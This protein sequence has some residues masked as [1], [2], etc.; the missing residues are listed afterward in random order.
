MNDIVKPWSTTIVQ[1]SPDD[2]EFELALRLDGFGLPNLPGL[3]TTPTWESTGFW[4]FDQIVKS[5]A[6]VTWAGS[7]FAP[8][9]IWLPSFTEAVLDM[10]PGIVDGQ[11]IDWLA[12][13]HVTIYAV[14]WE[15][16]GWN[17][18]KLQ[19]DPFFLKATYFQP[20]VGEQSQASFLVAR[21]FQVS[22]RVRC[23]ESFDQTSSTEPLG[24]LQRVFQLIDRDHGLP[25]N[26]C[27]SLH[28]F[29]IPDPCR[30]SL[31]GVTISPTLTWPHFEKGTEQ[32]PLSPFGGTAAQQG[33][34]A[35]FI[36]DF[37]RALV[38]SQPLT[39]D[40]TQINVIVPQSDPAACGFLTR[41]FVPDSQPLFLFFLC[42]R[43][44]T[45]LHCTMCE[46]ELHIVQFDGLGL[47][48]L[49]KL[50]PVADLLKQHWQARGVV[51]SNKFVA[52]Q[53]RPDSC[54][55]LALAHFAYVLD[56]ISLEQLDHFEKLHD[57]L[58]KSSNCRLYAGPT[59]LGKDA[60][61]VTQSLETILSEKGVPPGELRGRIQSAIKTFGVAAIAKALDNKT[62]WPALKTL[63][64]SR[65]KP[66]LWVS[67]QELQAHI[68]ARSKKEYGVDIRKPRKNKEVKPTETSILDSAALTL[69][70]GLFVTNSGAPLQQLALSQVQKDACGIAFASAAEA[71]PFL[72]NGKLISPE[73]LNLLVIGSLAGYQTALPQHS[74]RVPAIYKGTNEPILVDVTSVQLGD[75]AVYRKTGTDAPEVAVHPNVVV[76]AHI[77][78]D[79]W[80]EH[81]EWS[82]LTAHP[83]RKLVDT[84]PI[85]QLCRAEECDHQCPRYHPSI[86]ETGIE[87]GLLDVWGLRWT[88]YDGGKSTPADSEVLSVYLR[89]PESSFNSLH[90]AS[91]NC[92]VFYEPR[93][94]DNPGPDSRYSVVWHPKM[95][96]GEA[97]HLVKTDDV[98]IA[99]CR[100][101]HKIGLRCWAKN[102]E[103]LHQQVCPD[104]PF[105]NC[106]VKSVFRI[107]PLPAGT[108]R[109]SLVDILKAF[110]WVAKPLAPC[111]GS[112]GRA[113]QIGSE[114]PPPSAFFETKSGWVSITKVRDQ[115]T[116]AKTTDLIATART[117][118]HIQGQTPAAASSSSTS[119]PWN[120]GH[121]PWGG[122]AGVGKV[123]TAPPSQHV[124]SKFDDVEQRL[125]SQVTESIAKGLEQLQAEPATR[126]QQV[127][128]QL[129]V[130]AQ[131]QQFLDNRLTADSAKITEIQTDCSHLAAAVNTC[132]T[133]IADQGTALQA[134][135]TEVS[136]QGHSLKQVSSEVASVSQHLTSQLDSYFSRQTEQIEAMLAKRQRSN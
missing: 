4:I 126:I 118:Q 37:A 68:Q 82:E 120:V 102:Y 93:G 112:Q 103:A 36:L 50:R 89:I 46:E 88:K 19:L 100:L 47:T 33:L 136:T 83:I 66:F 69:P 51:L 65:P 63:G 18:V 131:Q 1:L 101:G 67:H 57:G 55:T 17:L 24:S 5:Q 45:F 14:V 20:F 84:F 90:H 114:T 39:I 27:E 91:G 104:K 30:R 15:T 135:A 34:P 60:D 9:A 25:A 58:V 72:S 38:Q 8:L 113:W 26:L 99:A 64:N 75:M 128:A 130:L 92:G 41:D 117:R 123:T 16:W 7:N 29:Q 129:Q 3:C 13:P 132:S 80:S 122:Y 109:Q 115:G 108:Q 48:P 11:I 111:R 52:P 73:G 43:H 97:Q 107:E 125:Q 54:G 86:E 53:Q 87:S 76:R 71:A 77:F 96:L 110:Q 42:D 98:C 119:E 79:L 134:I 10:W 106:S 61:A 116:P 2:L 105:V 12:R 40:A 124:Q 22:I 31:E 44:W 121:D 133:Q 74:L 35:G 94:Q 49:C 95:S 85:L 78:R 6:L 59:G 32:W 28:S 81:Q 21:A 23:V 70:P 62:P 56:L 127:E